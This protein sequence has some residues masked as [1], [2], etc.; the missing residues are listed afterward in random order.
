MMKLVFF[1]APGAGK[2]T[3][4][5]KFTENCGI[6][7]IST[8]DLFREAIKNKTELGEKVSK[9]ISLGE[10][11]PDEITIAMVKERIA[12]DDCKNGYI[13]DGFP[14][15]IGQAEKFEEV[16]PIDMAIFFEISDEDVKKR[17]GGR[18]VCEKCGAIYNVFFS[19]PKKDGICDKDGARLIIREDDKEETIIKRLE[20][21]HNQTAPLVDF[22]NKLNKLIRIDAT[23]EL[24]SIF[25]SIIEKL[26]I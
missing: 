25:N 5:K 17:L 1:G 18:R 21:Y 13:L 12:K 24:D 9:I 23:L 11:V 14:R 3:V 10:L 15:T 22:Y 2:G 26:K 8:G 19:K 6:P 4:A 16:N 7:Q 20:V